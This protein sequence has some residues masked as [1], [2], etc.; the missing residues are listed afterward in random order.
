MAANVLTHKA[1]GEDGY[2]LLTL[3]P[4]MKSE[5]VVAKDIVL[6]ADTSG[7]MQG[8]KM[9]QLKLALKYVVNALLRRQILNC[10]IQY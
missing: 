1:V 9:K 6:V 2:F 3:S 4:P 10:S 7:S 5:Q 8:E